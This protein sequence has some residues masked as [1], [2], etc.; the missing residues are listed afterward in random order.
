MLKPLF[1]QGFFYYN[2]G[3]NFPNFGPKVAKTPIFLGSFQTFEKQIF[4]KS[5]S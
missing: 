4:C 1:L 2:L 3:Q 5:W